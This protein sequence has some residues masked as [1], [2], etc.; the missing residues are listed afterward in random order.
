VRQR[1]DAID[2][3]KIRKRIVAGERISPEHI[4]D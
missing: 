2:A 4:R 3:V 1:H